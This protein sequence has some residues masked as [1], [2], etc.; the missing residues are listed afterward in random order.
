MY[1]RNI[2]VY[3][4]VQADTKQVFKSSPLPKN[5]QLSPKGLKIIPQSEL[6][7]IEEQEKSNTQ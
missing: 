7:Y 3:E 6:N 1:T 4:S 5:S 2:L